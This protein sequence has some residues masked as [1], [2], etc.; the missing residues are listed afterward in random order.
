MIKL[1]LPFPI[2]ANQYWRCVR[3][4][5]ICKV[6]VSKDAKKYKKSV[7]YSWMEQKLL[8]QFK[9]FNSTQRL[10][11]SLDLYPA[12]RNVHDTDNY[13]KVLLDALSGPL[14]PIPND[15]QVKHLKDI[16]MHDIEINRPPKAVIVIESCPDWPRTN[17]SDLSDTVTPI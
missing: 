9:P 13:L 7:G 14:M 16:R 11:V 4:K 8:N 15:R 17:E 6:L 10:Q 3:V 5:S 1:T 2:S 12:R